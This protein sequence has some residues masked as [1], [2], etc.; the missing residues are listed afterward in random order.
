MTAVVCCFKRQ[1][2]VAPVEPL[3]TDAIEELRA[4]VSG[5]RANMEIL[6][7]N[8]RRWRDV[9]SNAMNLLS[10]REAREDVERKTRQGKLDRW[11]WGLTIG[12]ALCLLLLIVMIALFVGFSLA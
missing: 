3:R 11:L 4:E 12:V 6:D 1:R 10:Q 9:T 8:M 2:G 5:V 7:V